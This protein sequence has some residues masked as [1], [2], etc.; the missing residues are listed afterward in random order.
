VEE[1]TAPLME[2]W[3]YERVAEGVAAPDELREALA[4]KRKTQ[5]AARRRLVWRDRLQKHVTHR[6]P[7][8]A[9]LNGSI[10]AVTEPA[11]R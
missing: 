6:H 10:D 1:E 3:G 5:A 2:R 7:L 9:R 8:A 4:A 11:H